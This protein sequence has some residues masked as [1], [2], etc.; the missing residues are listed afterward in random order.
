MLLGSSFFS[1][2]FF[3]SSE[4]KPIFALQKEM[5]AMPPGEGARLRSSM[6]QS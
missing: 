6:A 3:W 2:F 5:T 4:A 1:F